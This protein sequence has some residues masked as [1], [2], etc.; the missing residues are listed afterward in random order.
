[1]TKPLR[2]TEK[3]N[4]LVRLFYLLLA[5][6]LL[7]P[8]VSSAQEEEPEEGIKDYYRL[9]VIGIG[10]GLMTFNG[11]VG[12][13]T[14]LNSFNRFKPGYNLYIE[15]RFNGFL[16]VALNGSYGKLSANESRNLHRNFESKVTSADLSLVFHFDNGFILKKSNHTAPYLMAGISYLMF[17]P[18]GDLK[19]KNGNY[20]N[21]W[22]DQ[23]IRDLPEVDSN[24]AKAQLVP[25]D[26]KYETAL[27]DS[28]VKY[29]HNTFSIPL[30]AG[31]AVKINER[32]ALDLQSTYYLTMSD[33]I[34]NVK[35]GGPDR[36]LFTSAM[37]KIALSGHHME[38]DTRFSDV[39][40]DAI[41]HGDSDG[42]KIE[43][44]KDNCPATEKDV[45]VDSHGCPLDIDKDG[46]PD[47]KDKE[48]NSQAG[49]AVD[50][51]GI[52]LTDALLEKMHGDTLAERHTSVTALLHQKDAQLAQ[53]G[54]SMDNVKPLPAEFVS[55]DKNNDGIITSQEISAAID[56]FFEGGSQ[57]TVEKLHRLI[58]YFFEQ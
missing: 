18:M 44:A 35:D 17:N 21:Y 4:R 47:Y 23:S 34:D 19:D 38:K 27:K 14:Q 41:D 37:I 26:Y 15:Q 24:K 48:P 10:A 51:Y 22:S 56:E 3:S 50:V 12:K 7:V 9:P 52:T 1:M 54:T 36:Y 57:L 32:I 13:G 6:T 42:D 28:T 16:G 11:D 31:V 43:D 5:I 53:R 58:D 30:T 20:Y 33:F 45:K 46:V 39:D 8:A 55:A 49:Q 25:R 40:F 2:L 29:A